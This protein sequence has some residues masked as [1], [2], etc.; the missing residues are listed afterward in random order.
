MNVSNQKKLELFTIEGHKLHLFRT[1]NAGKPKLIFMS[2]SGT[3]S[4]MYDFKIL[5]EKLLEDFRVIVI[6]KFGYGYSDLFA[7]SCEIDSVIDMQRKV[8]EE[9]E[10]DGPYILV[11]HSLS[12]L[13]AIRWKQ[14][15][16]DE[17]QAIIGLDMATPKTYLAWKSDEVDRR[18]SIIRKMK[19]AKDKGLLFWLPVNKRGLTKEEIKEQ[20]IL[21]K[22]NA[23]N[24]C[25]IKEAEA[26][27][28]NAEKVAAAGKINCPILMFVSNGKQVSQNWLEHEKDFAEQCNAKIINLNC[29]HYVHYFESDLI[30]TEIRGFV[31]DC[32]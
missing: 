25:Y 17:V 1:G 4:P 32:L 15:Y 18:I 22:K 28:K 8:L 19:K 9:A 31:N 26:V 11:P 10:E 16:P 5:Y 23:F 7:A 24:E 30:S 29:G 14:K 13:E 2:G 21:W 20:K 3:A 27:L 6:E 12:G